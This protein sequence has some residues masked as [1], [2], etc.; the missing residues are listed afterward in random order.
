MT[1]TARI[2]LAALV[3]A[4]FLLAISAAGLLSASRLQAPP[5]PAAA[6]PTTSTAAHVAP[7]TTSHT[8]ND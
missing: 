4:L 5:A 1:D 8:E 7:T 2:K 3:T 6:A